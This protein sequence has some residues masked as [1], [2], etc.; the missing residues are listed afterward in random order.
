MLSDFI[1][2]DA[3]S[4]SN[5][6]VPISISYSR[7]TTYLNLSEERQTLIDNKSGLKFLKTKQERRSTIGHKR[8]RSPA[9]EFDSADD[10][11]VEERTSRRAKRAENEDGSW[12]DGGGKSSQD[13]GRRGSGKGLQGHNYQLRGKTGEGSR[14]D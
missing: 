6:S 3:T 11:Q 13:K 2:P 10:A 5:Q 7:L 14:A 8:K 9:E 1:L 4:P 12:S